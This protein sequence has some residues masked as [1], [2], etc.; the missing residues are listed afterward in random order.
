VAIEE[1]LA[2]KHHDGSLDSEG[3]FTVDSLKADQKLADFYQ[4]HPGLWI[5]PI[6]Q[7]ASAAGSTWISVK[8]R[9]MSV[10]V[11]FATMRSLPVYPLN[12]HKGEY[13]ELLRR[14]IQG[15][16]CGEPNFE[17]FSILCRNPP[18]Q[19]GMTV[20]AR[21][22]KI[23]ET[24]A[25]CQEMLQ[26]VEESIER[27]SGWALRSEMNVRDSSWVLI[28]I[29]IRSGSWLESL[30]NSVRFRASLSKALNKRLNYSVIPIT[31]DGRRVGLGSNWPYI[32]DAA[33][34]ILASKFQDSFVR[35]AEPGC[36]ADV[37][38]VFGKVVKGYKDQVRFLVRWSRV[39]SPLFEP[40][41][42]PAV[43]LEFET[44]KARKLSQFH[45]TKHSREGEIPIF[46]KHDDGSNLARHVLKF[47]PE[48]QL[49]RPRSWLRSHQGFP[50]SV[51]LV[52]PPFPKQAR[53]SYLHFHRRGV[54][55]D[56]VPID[57]LY[58]GAWCLVACPRLKTD[59]SGFKLV[60]DETFA[61]LE[62]FLNERLKM[63]IE[64]TL[65]QAEIR[66]RKLD[67]LNKW[68]TSQGWEATKPPPG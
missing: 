31:L 60:R 27:N 19:S 37:F 49:D 17:S 25:D 42:Q 41:P 33:E 48:F 2:D 57:L 5:L 59:F 66:G 54:L 46:S 11:K 12:G 9:R 28:Q 47:E 16:A 65:E 23:V 45:P 1:F 34:Y 13:I 50:T 62:A 39:E 35:E 3:A 6:L 36:G 52:L 68:V 30:R 18:Y 20:L 22:E 4:S 67:E 51:M 40:I 24:E 15:A 61:E 7:A 43:H 64:M 44:A 58:P 8:I 38:D 14:G 56:K 63:L 32:A 26:E 10:E 55:L 29:K 21:G 53:D